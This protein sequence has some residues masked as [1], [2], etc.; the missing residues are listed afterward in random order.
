[1]LKYVS[2]IFAGILFVLFASQASAQGVEYRYHHW[3]H[4]WGHGWYWGNGP[5][6]ESPAEN[7]RRS[8]RYDHLLQ[9]NLR[10]RAYRIVKE[11]GPIK[12]PALHEDCVRSFD[13]F[14]PIAPYAGY[15]WGWH[16]WRHAHWC[17]RC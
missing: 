2:P 10:F 15:G 16:H 17:R 6:W 1:M 13:V 8:Q 14:E 12:D 11:C 5:W 3:Y 7:V 4:P 9:V